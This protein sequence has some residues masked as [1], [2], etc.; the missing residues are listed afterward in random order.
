[1]ARKDS[2]QAMLTKVKTQIQQ[3][4]VGYD[5][6]LHTQ[7]VDAQ[8]RVDIKNACENLRSVLD[9]I[10]QDIRER[11]CPSAPA[12]GR[13]YF[14]ILPDKPT[15]DRRIDEWLLGLRK[16]APAV[17]AALESM[18]PFQRGQEWLG[19]F[20]QVNNDNKHR[21]LV[22][23]TRV[24]RTETRVTGQGGQVSWGPGVTFGPGVFVMGVPIDPRTQLP[25]PDPSVKVERITWVDFHFAGMRVSAMGLLRQALH[26]GLLQLPYFERDLR[27]V[28]LSLLYLGICPFGS[29]RERFVNGQCGV[30]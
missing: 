8:L 18:Q 5:K 22:E 17:V 25:V 30:I 27:K 21:D 19:Q 29:L 14:P 11:Y 1:M 16:A 15:F 24:E 2:I 7:S 13:F 6:S 28:G 4:Q 20:N 10:A 26:F 3:I 9:Y 12:N 23:Q